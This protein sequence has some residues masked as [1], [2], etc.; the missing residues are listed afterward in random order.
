[1]AQYITKMYERIDKVAE[2]YYGSANNLI[3]EFVI[4]SNPGLEEHG[5]VLPPGLTIELPDRPAENQEV[6]TIKVYKLW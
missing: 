5:I 4:E 1:M 2:K 6:P 3:T